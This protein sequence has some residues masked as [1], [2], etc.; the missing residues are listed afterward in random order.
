MAVTSPQHLSLMSQ[1]LSSLLARGSSLQVVT[2]LGPRHVLTLNREL[3][4]LHSPFLRSLLS[5]S[6]S[7]SLFLP[8]TLPPA[9]LSLEQLLER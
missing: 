8:D 4:L 5:S 7:S 9:L 2:A 1:A 3:L 6:S